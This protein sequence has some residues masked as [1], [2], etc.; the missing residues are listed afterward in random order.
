VAVDVHLVEE[1]AG[2]VDGDMMLPILPF[3]R[4]RHLVNNRWI[5]SMFFGKNVNMRN[6]K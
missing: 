4:G 6:M 1:V 2:H 5:R 3:H